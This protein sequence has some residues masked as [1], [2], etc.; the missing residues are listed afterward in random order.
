MVS[1]RFRD[2][3]RRELENQVCECGFR[4][5]DFG[6]Y[7]TEIAELEKARICTRIFRTDSAKV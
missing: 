5:F 7:E 3:M 1:E 4:V 6:H 2:E